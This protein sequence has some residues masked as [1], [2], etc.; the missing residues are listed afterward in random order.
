M[1]RVVATVRIVNLFQPEA[2]IVCDALV[3]TG[4]AYMG[5]PKVW[6]DRLGKIRT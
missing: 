2:F 6:K 4:S 3:D 5:L 1:G